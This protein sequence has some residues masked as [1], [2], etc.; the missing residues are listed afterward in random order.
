M[1]VG[2]ILIGDELLS[3]LRQD[4][5]MPQVLTFLKAR[6]LQLAWVRMVGDDRD[7]LVQTLRETMQS[8]EIV[9]SFGGI[10]ATP[11]DLTRQAAAAAAGV[12]LLRHPQAVAL[13]EDCFGEGAYPNR[14]R[15]SE[16]PDGCTLIPNSVNRMPGFKLGHHHFVP[17]FPNMSWP[18]IEWVLDN[19]YRQYFDSA[20]NVEQRWLLREVRES[21]LI[22]MMETLLQT[23]PDVRLSSLPSTTERRQID[24]GLK[25]KS[26]AVQAAGEWFEARMLAGNTSCERLA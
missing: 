7:L 12:R 17:G 2:L 14:I 25:G 21:D 22:P 8:K 10:G 6:G 19:H 5:H 16:L 26:A 15:M 24:F 18:M 13:I 1:K 3:G 23:F 4:K 11:D 20:P 9:F